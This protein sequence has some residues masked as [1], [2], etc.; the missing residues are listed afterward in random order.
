MIY[1]N[2][3]TDFVHDASTFQK[4]ICVLLTESNSCA[5]LTIVIEETVEAEITVEDA[6]T[7]NPE[8]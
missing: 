4:K 2:F 1:R 5:I 7:E 3:C 8:C 6:F